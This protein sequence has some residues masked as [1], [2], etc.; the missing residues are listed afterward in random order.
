MYLKNNRFDERYC[1]I[2]NL[3]ENKS[4]FVMIGFGLT[5]GMFLLLHVLYHSEISTF[6]I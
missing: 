4:S 1:Y 2:V 5:R 3:Q 6:V